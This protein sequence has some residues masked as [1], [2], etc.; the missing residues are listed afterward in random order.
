MTSSFQSSALRIGITS[1]SWRRLWSEGPSSIARGR[2][3]RK[4]LS[5]NRGGE[6]VLNKREKWLAELLAWWDS[7]F[8]GRRSDL[9]LTHAHLGHTRCEGKVRCAIS[10]VSHS[11]AKDAQ[12][13]GTPGRWFAGG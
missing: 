1:Q 3:S 4:T 11:C 2:L 9:Y 10:V 8:R 5:G 12:E 13:W 6:P 7:A